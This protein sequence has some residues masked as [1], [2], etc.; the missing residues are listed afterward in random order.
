[1]VYGPGN[2]FLFNSIY[3][4]GSSGRLEEET[5]LNKDDSLN[6]RLVFSY[7]PN[8]RQSGYVVYDAA[9]K[10]IGQTTPV[11]AP[12]PPQREKPGKKKPK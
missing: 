11:Q 8:G 10:V 2:K 1:M 4:Y 6:S 7:D 5:R 12:P 3:K 9:G